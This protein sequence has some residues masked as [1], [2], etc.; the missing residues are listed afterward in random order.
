MKYRSWFPNWVPETSLKSG[1]WKTSPPCSH[2]KLSRQHW[3]LD[4]PPHPWAEVRCSGG[5]GDVS[6]WSLSSWTSLSHWAP[7]WVP[8][9]SLSHPG[10]HTSQLESIFHS[11]LTVWRQWYLSLGSSSSLLA[12]LCGSLDGGPELLRLLHV[13]VAIPEKEGVDPG[14]LG[15]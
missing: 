7:T 15:V 6:V 11:Q 2:Y 1:I 9:V 12:R 3:L 5:M 4:E 8:D 10:P 13:V 14:I